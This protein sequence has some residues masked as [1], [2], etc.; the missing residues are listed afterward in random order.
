MRST[1]L[2]R[3]AAAGA[4]DRSRDFIRI[5]EVE[6]IT[7]WDRASIKRAMAGGKFPAA[8]AL[9]PRVSRWVR[10]EVDAWVAEHGKQVAP[11]PKPPP[12]PPKPEMFGPPRPNPYQLLNEEQILAQA[13]PYGAP[14][15]YFLIRDGRIVYIGQSINVHARVAQHRAKKRFDRWHW[16]PVSKRRLDIMEQH[17]IRHF[18]PE[19]NAVYYGAPGQEMDAAPELLSDRV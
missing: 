17:Y 2:Q 3:G 1:R 14:G 8:V 5:E 19:L 13:A 11:L 18:R 15:I 9:G 16:V 10:G 6:A 12:P 4:P 7:G